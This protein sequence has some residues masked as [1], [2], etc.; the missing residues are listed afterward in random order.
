[1]KNKS[2]LILACF[3][4]SV[5]LFAQ[6]NAKK[7]MEMVFN[8]LVSAYGTAKSAP[9]VI[10]ISDQKTPAFYTTTPKPSIKIDLQ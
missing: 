8:Q 7:Q 5:T 6:S 4:F 2:V 1:M 9:Q 3:L 10:F